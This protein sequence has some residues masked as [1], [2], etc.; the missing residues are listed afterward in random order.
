VIPEGTLTRPP[1]AE[2]RPDQR[3]D[4]DLP[5]YDVLDPLISAA[6]VE[7]R[8]WEELVSRFGEGLVK[9]ALRRLTR[10]EYKRKQLPLVLKVSPKAFGMGRR[11]PI[12]NRFSR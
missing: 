6:V 11:W 10:S 8:P 5:P 1:S 4:Q 3:D 9:E 7:N 12:T 2:L